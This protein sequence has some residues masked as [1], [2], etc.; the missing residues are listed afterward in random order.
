VPFHEVHAKISFSAYL[1]RFSIIELVN[2]P[3]AQFAGR[4][5]RNYAAISAFV[6]AWLMVVAA[7]IAFST[8]TYHLNESPGIALGRRLITTRRLLRQARSPI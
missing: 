2:G 7:A 4:D 8:F 3:L 6:L 1:V 5:A